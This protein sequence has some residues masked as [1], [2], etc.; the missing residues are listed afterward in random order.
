MA[1]VIKILMDDEEE[2]R[3][4]VE[5]LSKETGNLEALQEFVNGYIEITPYP[6]DTK[7]FIVC[8]ES[9]RLLYEY[10]TICLSKNGCMFPYYGNFIICKFGD[11]GDFDSLTE[12]EVDEILE[13]IF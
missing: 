7:Y 4:N 5:S 3:V 6:L 8:N 11:D 1:R 2:F 12:E 9:G 10:P 13:E